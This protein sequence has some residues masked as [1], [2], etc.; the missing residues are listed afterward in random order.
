M[1]AISDDK[2]EAR[3]GRTSGKASFADFFDQQGTYKLA[4]DVQAA[5]AR[6]PAQ[7]NAYDNNVIKVDDRLNVA[8]QVYHGDMYRFFPSPNRVY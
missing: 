7:R 1:I 5:Y 3:L 4:N 8:Y 2:I 6:N